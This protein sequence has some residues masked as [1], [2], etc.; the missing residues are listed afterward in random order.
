M[1]DARSAQ[2]LRL[3][4]LVI[5]TLLAALGSYWLLQMMRQSAA[6]PVLQQKRGQPDYQVQNFHF[7][8][9]TE[10]GQA[11]Y[12]L[13]GK[14]LLHYPVDDA[15]EIIMPVAKSINPNQAPTTIHAERARLLENNQHIQLL[16]NVNISRPASDKAEAMQLKSPTLLIMTESDTMQTDDPVEILF[17][18]S[19]L[20]GTGLQANS[21]TGIFHLSHKVRGILHPH[22]KP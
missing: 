5:L 7:I 6:P 10:N 12:L 21:A 19:L 8:R 4:T 14:T 3:I 13:S 1:S 17:G 9:T 11:H 15:I 20:F 18:Q 2:R 22:P 16:G